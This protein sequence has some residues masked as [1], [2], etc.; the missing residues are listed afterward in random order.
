MRGGIACVLP[1][2][3]QIVLNTAE[4][5]LLN[6]PWDAVPQ[7]TLAHDITGR[8]AG[9]VAGERVKLAALDT[10]P[11]SVGALESVT[12]TTATCIREVPS[13]EEVGK[14]VKDTP[15]LKNAVASATKAL[16]VRKE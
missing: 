1:P 3:S 13:L 14:G 7:D 5:L 2:P 9:L 10:T 16:T 4:V 15:E 11:T 8:N 12:A 6:P